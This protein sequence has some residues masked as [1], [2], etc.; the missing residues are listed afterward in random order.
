MR[1]K[2]NLVQNNPKAGGAPFCRVRFEPV[3]PKST[4]ML[5]PLKPHGD[6]TV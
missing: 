6:S 1:Y 2:E 5:V 4:R 3:S